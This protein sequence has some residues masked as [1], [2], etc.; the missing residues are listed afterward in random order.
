MRGSKRLA[1]GIRQPAFYRPS[2]LHCVSLSLSLSLS[3]SLREE[4]SVVVVRAFPDLAQGLKTLKKVVGKKRAK[5]ETQIQGRREQA[6]V[7][8]RYL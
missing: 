8:K 4:V 5:E 6:R 3:H 1:E 7:G 2:V